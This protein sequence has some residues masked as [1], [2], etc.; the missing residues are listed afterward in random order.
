[1]TGATA[2]LVAPS[3]CVNSFGRG[4][5]DAI[6]GRADIWRS[7]R[8]HWSDAVEP[9]PSCEAENSC[10]QFASSKTPHRGDRCGIVMASMRSELSFGGGLA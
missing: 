6:G 8:L 1:M 4:H 10:L 3:L 9:K 2:E 5:S 7:R